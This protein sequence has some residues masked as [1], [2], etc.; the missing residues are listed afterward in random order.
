MI[1]V[2]FNQTSSPIHAVRTALQCLMALECAPDRRKPVSA[3]FTFLLEFAAALTAL[4]G[5]YRAATLISSDFGEPAQRAV[6]P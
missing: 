2:S 4:T 6:S 3:K 1:A 5:G